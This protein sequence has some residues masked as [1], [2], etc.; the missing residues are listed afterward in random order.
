M[1][2][3]F[4][5]DIICSPQQAQQELLNA[6]KEKPSFDEEFQIYFFKNE[7]E[8]ELYEKS[9]LQKNQEQS[10]NNDIFNEITVQNYQKICQTHIEKSSFL[11]AEFWSHLNEYNP[12]LGK[13]SDI[14]YKI[15]ICKQNIENYWNRLMKMNV[16]IPN[17]ILLYSKFLKE[18]M[19]DNESSLQILNK[20]IE[21]N[22]N[23]QASK[24]T[25]NIDIQT[26]SQPTIIISADD[27]SFCHIIN[28]NLSVC[29]LSLYQKK[30]LLSK[31]ISILMPQMY[32]KNHDNFIQR[33][34]TTLEPRVLNVDN[35]VPFKTKL[36]YIYI[37]KILIKHVSSLINGLQFIAYFKQSKFL[38]EQCSLII[39]K[40]G[41]IQDISSSCITMLGLD[42]KKLSKKENL[43]TDCIENFWNHLKEFQQKQGLTVTVQNFKKEC[44]KFQANVTCTEINFKISGNLG[45][46]I[47]ISKQFTGLLKEKNN[48][49]TSQQLPNF[50]LYM[51]YNVELNSFVG[52]QSFGKTCHINENSNTETYQ[53]HIIQSQ[54]NEDDHYQSSFKS[55]SS[56]KDTQQRQNINYQQGIKTLVLVNNQLIDLEIIKKNEQQIEDILDSQNEYQEDLNNYDGNNLSKNIQNNENKCY[57]N[58]VFK[59]KKK[60]IEF[61]EQTD[62]LNIPLFQYF[63]IISFVFIL[64]IVGLSSLNN[65]VSSK[66][67]SQ[68]TSLF[69]QIQYSNE[70][71][72]D[73]QRI[74]LKLLCL[75][76]VETGVFIQND[77]LIN[78][79][80]EIFEN[81]KVLSDIIIQNENQML[82]LERKNLISNN[83]VKMTFFQNEKSTF[84]KYFDLYEATQQIISKINEIVGQKQNKQS[85]I[86]N[87]QNPTFYFLVNNL[88]N[89]YYEK[90]IQQSQ[91]LVL[92]LE[93]WCMIKK[94]SQIALLIISIAIIISFFFILI[95]YY[96]IINKYQTQILDV[97]LEIPAEKVKKLFLKS[98]LFLMNL[99]NIDLDENTSQE[100]NQTQQQQEEQQNLIV[101]NKQKRK[102]SK[103]NFNKKNQMFF[104]PFF[105]YCYYQ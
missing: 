39:N 96:F 13:L 63:K 67:L 40:N 101:K 50:H 32:A 70:L 44:S 43:I 17:L 75:H 90:L 16:F 56:L 26:Y 1:Y 31:N 77:T 94:D 103:T 19:N 2:A 66:E 5:F 72:S 80:S 47:Q 59:N 83:V 104:L 100:I 11:Y 52:Y 88:L 4:L 37:S 41:I 12:D 102:I 62:F 45:Q 34:L 76:L 14:G 61:I 82:S 68:V 78:D 35:L 28:L 65:I 54:R 18:I 98:E 6:K 38:K 3:I 99:Q 93:T 97:F 30:E 46:I 73:M 9:L 27:D 95:F 33:Y 10:A 8:N 42:I 7:V 48:Q 51:Y 58:N 84:I 25:N 60:F 21:V 69:N 64:V 74:V 85:I 36:G 89:D 53:T 49:K 20:L 55:R 29:Q 87:Y 71:N 79:I 92:E 24:S 15:Y 81:I 23:N 91:Y 57:Q 105:S 22:F 86:F